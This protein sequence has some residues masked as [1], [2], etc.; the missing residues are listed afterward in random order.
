QEVVYGETQ[1]SQAHHFS[2]DVGVHRLRHAGD[3]GSHQPANREEDCAVKGGQVREGFPT[4]MDLIDRLE[5]HRQDGIDAIEFR[6]D[7]LLTVLRWNNTPQG[8]AQNRCE[9]SLKEVME[10]IEV[11]APRDR[12]AA[13]R[14]VF[15]AAR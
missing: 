4:L 6:V 14:L 7:E 9:K 8:Q 5:E 11:L 13:L 2:R 1:E 15:K 3:I 12:K 10:Y